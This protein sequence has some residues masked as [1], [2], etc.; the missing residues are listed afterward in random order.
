[1]DKK[2][3]RHKLRPRKKRCPGPSQNRCH[4]RFLIRTKHKDPSSPWH[5]QGV[6]LNGLQRGLRLTGVVKAL[7][8]AVKKSPVPHNKPLL[9]WI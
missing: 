1:M 4:E 5:G 9:G 3:K 7:T 8:E 6:T 2:K